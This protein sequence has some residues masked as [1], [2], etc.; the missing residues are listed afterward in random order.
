M[1]LLPKK[2]R[3]IRAMMREAKKRGVGI[4]ELADLIGPYELQKLTGLYP[5][6]DVTKFG[7]IPDEQVT[8]ENIHT[9]PALRNAS[10]AA[11][12]GEWQ[13]AAMLVTATWD[14]WETRAMV[15]SRLA[16][17][18]ADD[19]TWLKAWQRAEPGNPHAVVVDAE[20]LVYLAWQIR[21]GKWA[22]QT[23]EAQFAGFHHTL[24][25]AEKTAWQAAELLPSDP[26]PWA[27]LITLGRGLSVDHQEFDRRW[28]GLIERAPLH[29]RG[30]DAALQYWCAKWRGSHERMVAFAQESAAKSPS[31]SGLLIRAAYEWEDA[32]ENVWHEP[33]AQ[34]GLTTFL[35]WLSSD[36]PHNH[37]VHDDLGW[38]I[39]ALRRTKREPEA[40]PLFQRLGA[41]AGGEPWT[42]YD[43]PVASFCYQR[44]DIC[45]MAKKR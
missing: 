3:A 37:H 36:G 22:S 20:A 2:V 45:L 8:K 14:D 13:P 6:V 32:H 42:Y 18:A 16:R 35:R 34:Q 33:W 25:E 19:D 11:K 4:D 21:G 24:E 26:T 30:H 27:T 39:T 15:V 31:L 40:I 23:S 1:P 28:Q 41:Y 38:A 9:D 29:R 5:D 12:R 7:L 10:E 43:D 17:I 44:A